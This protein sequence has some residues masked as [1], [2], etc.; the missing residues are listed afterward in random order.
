MKTTER[1][2]CLRSGINAVVLVVGGS[3]SRDPAAD[4]CLLNSNY[5][6]GSTMREKRMGISM[7]HASISCAIMYRTQASP[8]VSD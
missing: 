7:Q 1:Q 5:L 8:Q 3:T 2:P 4:V 6:Q